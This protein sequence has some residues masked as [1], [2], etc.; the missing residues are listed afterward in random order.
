MLNTCTAIA[1][2]VAITAT[3][4]RWWRSSCIGPLGDIYCSC[5]CHNTTSS[6]LFL[7]IH[8]FASTSTSTPT[9]L[10]RASTIGLTPTKMTLPLCVMI[11]LVF[12]IKRT[13]I[14]SIFSFI[15]VLCWYS[16]SWSWRLCSCILLIAV[17]VG[18]VLATGTVGNEDVVVRCTTHFA[19]ECYGWIIIVIIIM[20]YIVSMMYF[21]Q[22]GT[23][24]TIPSDV[25]VIVVIIII[26]MIIIHPM[27]TLMLML[28]T[29]II[30]SIIIRILH[31]PWFVCL[32][33]LRWWWWWHPYWFTN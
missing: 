18:D 16:W 21:I 5:C 30:F 23:C 1:I 31:P 6:R 8:T 15:G 33:L 2:A 13:M 29:T 11:V 24:V 28:M 26:I 32:L 7:V 19:I 4:T 9:L 17:V 20:R 22:I 14:F 3:T 27:M 12:Q 10:L 25:I